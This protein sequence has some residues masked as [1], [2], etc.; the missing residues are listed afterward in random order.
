MKANLHLHSRFSDGS[1][2]PEEVALQAAR[3]GLA[4][5]ALTDHDTMGG[6]ERFIAACAKLGLQGIAAC[7]IDVDEPDI[8][9]KSEL[10]AYFPGRAASDCVRTGALL[11]RILAE[12]T[13][14]LEYYLCCARTMFKRDDLTMADISETKLAGALPD[15]RKNIGGISWSKVDFF[16]Y[17]RAKELIP[18]FLSYKAF[19]KN[20]FAPGKFPAYRLSKP[21]VKECVDAIHSDGGFA[22]LPHFGHFWKDDSAAMERQRDKIRSQLGFFRA[23]GVDGIELYWYLGRKKS[24]AINAIVAELAAPLG[25]FFTFGS[26]CHGPGTGKH[27]I[28]KFYGDFAGFPAR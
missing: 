17:L 28:D 10:L 19:K 21:R 14:R 4:A 8:A 3:R 16:L 7:E 2:W 20:W 5:A 15:E 12:R 26:D 1:G 27:T 18:S 13:K 25:Y 23:L 6:A 9:Y 22:V 11:G 24:Q